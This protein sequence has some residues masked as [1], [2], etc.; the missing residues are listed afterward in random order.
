MSFLEKNQAHPAERDVQQRGGCAVQ[1]RVPIPLVE[2]SIL[3][4]A[5]HDK[6]IRNMYVYKKRTNFGSKV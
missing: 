6:Y 1:W 4:F 3:V 2:K 5:I